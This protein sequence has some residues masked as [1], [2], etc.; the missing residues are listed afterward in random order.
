M[1]EVHQ[2][3]LNLSQDAPG[4]RLAQTTCN[5]TVLESVCPASFATNKSLFELH[6]IAKRSMVGTALHGVF[7][8]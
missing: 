6:S 5:M 2:H 7:Y 4:K 8:F 3:L 1:E